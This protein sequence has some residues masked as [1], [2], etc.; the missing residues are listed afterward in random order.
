[1]DIE[2]GYE[3]DVTSLR[4]H[5]ADTEDNH[6]LKELSLRSALDEARQTEDRLNDERRRLE[7]SLDEAGTKLIESKLRLSAA[8]GSVSALQSQ[9]SQVNSRRLNTQTKLAS[10]MSSLRRF[11]GVGDTGAATRSKSLSPQ[12]RSAPRSRSRSPV[13]GHCDTFSP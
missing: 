1:M 12:R 8:D 10:V 7:R 9:L 2:C 6:R 11:V 4:R 3:A 13:K 5:L